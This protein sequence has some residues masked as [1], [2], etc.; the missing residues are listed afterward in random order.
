MSSSDSTSSSVGDVLARMKAA[1]SLSYD[2]PDDVVL[3]SP[4][5]NEHAEKIVSI[6]AAPAKTTPSNAP[7]VPSHEPHAQDDS[8]V[9][10]YMNRL[11]KR[12]ASSQSAPTRQGET[13]TTASV[14]V[15]P[16]AIEEPQQ[17]MTKEEFV[18]KT[19]APEKKASLNAFRE[20]ANHSNRA[21][22]ATSV[23]QQHRANKLTYLAVFIT[24]L[25]FG[26]LFMFMS[27]SLFDAS[28]IAGFASFA[29]AIIPML[30]FFGSH[31]ST[32]PKA[33]GRD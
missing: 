24:V 5:P 13:V 33:T 29:I 18:P 1:G 26:V 10:D 11:L 17:A 12:S 31:R 7:R 6:Q 22:I 25:G 14:Q 2:L 30:K 23:K 9:Q 19:V 20:L 32:K 27:A 4:Q 8:D 28:M 16:V 21:A 15:A 3:G